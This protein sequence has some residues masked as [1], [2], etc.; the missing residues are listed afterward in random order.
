MDEATSALD[1]ETEEIIMRA[2]YELKK[3]IT[4]ILIT[5]RL[6]TMEICDKLILLEKGEIKEQNSFKNK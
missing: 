2:V 4:I 6:S 1:S 3:K 5:H